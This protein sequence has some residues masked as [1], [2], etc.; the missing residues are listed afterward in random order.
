MGTLVI[1]VVGALAVTALKM[2]SR[3]KLLVSRSEP[4]PKPEVQPFTLLTR[5]LLC[6]REGR[7]VIE[8]SV[9]GPPLDGL[10]V[11]MS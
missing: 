5:I 11:S 8:A 2:R 1:G 3:Q 9:L 6:R 10:L 4:S 7:A